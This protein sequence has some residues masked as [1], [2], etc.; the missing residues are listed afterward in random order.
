MRNYLCTL[1]LMLGTAAASGQSKEHRLGLSVGGGPQ[2]YKGDLG[3]GFKISNPKNDVWRG[4]F[5][6]NASYYLSRSF[7]V[8]A[9]GSAG[10]FGYC[11]P[12]DVANTPVDDA[13]R[14]DGCVGRVGLGNLNSRFVSLGVSGRYKFAN[15]YLL[16][17]NN[18]FRPYVFAGVAVNRVLD[19]MKMHC[20][21][22]GDYMSLNAGAGVKYYITSRI[23]VGY[24]LSFGY[25][26]SDKVDGMV[27]GGSDMYRQ[28]SLLLGMDLF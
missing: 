9:F 11:Q 15:G 26:T 6:F 27:H 21:N 2:K 25:F 8:S 3:D 13:D 18:R 16:K 20:V 4:A 17:E 14:C 23:S 24:Q 12:A 10:D 1:L 22:T 28:S 7:D 5:V 19:H